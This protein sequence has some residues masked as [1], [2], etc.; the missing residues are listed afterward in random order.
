MNTWLSLLPPILTIILAIT[1]RQVYVSLLIGLISGAF[2]LS[3]NFITGLTG[4]VDSIISVFSSSYSTQNILFIILIGAVVKVV[5]KSGGIKGFVYVVTERSRLVKSKK[6]AQLAAYVAGL[7]MF[8]E[9]IGSMMV[10]GL[11]GKPLFDKYKMSREKLAF[12]ANSTGSPIAWIFPLGGAG[13]FLMGMLGGQVESGVISG[14]PLSFVLD[15]IPF[16]IYTVLLILSIPVMILLGKDKDMIVTKKEGSEKKEKQADH[17]NQNKDGDTSA[18]GH[19]ENMIM[20]LVILVVSVFAIVLITGKGNIAAGD[21][22]SAVYW[23]VFL[24]I[25]I[26]GIVFIIRKT[27]T[28]NEY[29]GWCMEGIQNMVPAATILI[30]AFALGG[31]TSQL[32]TG[33]YLSNLLIGNM[34]AGFIPALIFVICC[35]ISFS[36]GSSG[37]A[38]GIMIPIT[39]PLAVTAG[40]SIPLIIGAVISGAVFGDQSSPISDSVIVSSSAAECDPMDHFRTQ[41]PYTSVVALISLVLFVLL[42][43]IV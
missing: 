15:A 5:E 25:A 11:V 36:T 8:M 19:I 23:G 14:A 29:V 12:T 39:I 17:S 9:G 26:T 2:I 42:G 37:A 40:V 38:A 21:T 41:L 20:P 16:Q 1:T 32:Q 10:S 4:G 13:A 35:M 22:G 43:F 6:G 18:S 7:L 34:S 28:L 27:A 24:A 33:V 31:I 30:L 3:G